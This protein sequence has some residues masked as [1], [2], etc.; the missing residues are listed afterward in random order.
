MSKSKASYKFTTQ[1][2]DMSYVLHHHLKEEQIR[3]NTKTTHLDFSI[4]S[5]IWYGLK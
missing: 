4:E 5:L 3:V 1:I 2:E